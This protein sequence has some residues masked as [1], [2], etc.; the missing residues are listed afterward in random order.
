[1]KLKEIIKDLAILE[2]HGS[3]DVEIKNIRYN[4]K[5]VQKGDIFVAIKGTLSDGHNYI[6]DAVKKGASVVIYQNNSIHHDITNIK[7]NDSR[8]TLAQISDRFF[9]SPSKDLKLIGITGTNGKTT[10]S[11]LI[12][13]I[14][15]ASGSNAGLMGTILYKIGDE[16]VDASLTTPESPEIHS[17]LNKVKNK[18]AEY[19]VLE[20][21]SHALKQ[22]RTYGLKFDLAV[23]TNISRDHLDYH[24]NMEDYIE[25][26]LK[27]FN[28]L[29]NKYSKAVINSD[30]PVSE[31]I[32]IKDLKIIKYAAKKNTDISPMEYRLSFKG[33]WLKVNTPLGIMEINSK[34]IGY[35]NIYNILAA[36]GAG[37]SLNLDKNT[38]KEGIE[39][40]EQISGRA[41]KLEVAQ[42][43]NVIIDYSHTPDSVFNIIST[44]K[45]ITSGK[46][47]ALFGCGGDRDRGKRPLMGKIASENAD[48]IIVTSDNP[49]TEKPDEIIKNIVEGISNLE[50]VI[51]LPDRK[52]AIIK[53]LTIAE[54]YDSVLILGKGHENYQIIGKDKIPFSDKEI[55]VDFLKKSLTPDFNQG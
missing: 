37:I 23:F 14:I 30:D 54:E 18:N 12:K 8:K 40:T 34:L 5:N 10:V 13:N 41:E 47:I 31:R 3:E 9:N 50:N 38:I 21:S 1:M 7:V 53:A 52:E 33:I 51:I 27:L 2:K 45:K 16:S 48:I 39:K 43:F 29:N 25:S 26:K 11:Y 17:F 6:E 20:V 44:V 28:Q 24:P 36:I 15:E 35:F 49:R 32:A 46:V 55:A 19:V 42:K 22:N 4:S